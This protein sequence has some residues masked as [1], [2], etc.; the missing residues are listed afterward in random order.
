M[1]Q[2]YTTRL[3]IIE[4]CFKVQCDKKE[5]SIELSVEKLPN[6]FI[7]NLNNVPSVIGSDEIYCIAW[8]TCMIY[9]S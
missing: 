4:V 2:K 5:S 3:L 7:G 1:I 6:V 8:Y 9:L